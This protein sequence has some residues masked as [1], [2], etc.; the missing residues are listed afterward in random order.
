MAKRLNPHRRLLAKQAALR[1]AVQLEAGDV[2]AGKLQKGR[3]RSPLAKTNPRRQYKYLVRPHSKF[4]DEP[5]DRPIIP[6]S[7]KLNR[8]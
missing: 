7:A 4:G 8:Y 6:G 2:D 5:P 3:V 1:N